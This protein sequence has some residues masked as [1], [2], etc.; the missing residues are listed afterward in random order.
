MVVIIAL[1]IVMLWLL[2]FITTFAL[3]GLLTALFVLSLVF[4]VAQEI[5][6]GEV[7]TDTV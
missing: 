7:S 5:E 2:G 6:A 1:G 3:A 4:L